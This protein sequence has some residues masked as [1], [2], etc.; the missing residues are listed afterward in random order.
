M[1]TFACMCAA[2]TCIVFCHLSHTLHDGLNWNHS[3]SFQHQNGI[4]DDVQTRKVACKRV[5]GDHIHLLRN[6]PTILEL[7]WWFVNLNQGDV[8]TV[9]GLIITV[10]CCYSYRSTHNLT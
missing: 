9:T 6:L 3:H 8:G 10:S 5:L 2:L 1:V 7:G 4:N